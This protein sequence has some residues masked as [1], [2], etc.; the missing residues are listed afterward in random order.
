MQ[1]RT[2]VPE[3]AEINDVVEH[4]VRELLSLYSEGMK[5]S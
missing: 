4:L 5:Y 3:G 2:V 1:L